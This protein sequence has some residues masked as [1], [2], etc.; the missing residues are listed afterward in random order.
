MTGNEIYE[1]LKQ[2]SGSKLYEENKETSFQIL[3]KTGNIIR[4]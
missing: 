3:Q 1:M 2:M 4:C